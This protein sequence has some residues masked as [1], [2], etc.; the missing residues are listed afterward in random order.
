MY[1]II[2]IVSQK[3]LNETN[4]F[5]TH[6]DGTIPKYEIYGKIV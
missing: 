3:Y 4:G 5:N 2:R 6:F 1:S